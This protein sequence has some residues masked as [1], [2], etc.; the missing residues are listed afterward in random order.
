[1]AVNGSSDREI[2]ESFPAS[3]IR[4]NRGVS[5]VRSLRINRREEPPQVVLLYGA[6][7]TGKT[8]S[9]MS[10][11]EDL[12]QTPIG[13]YGWFDGY[14][15][16]SDVLLDDFAGKMSKCSLAELL[17]LIDRYSRRVPIKG[18]FTRFSPK[19]I[20]ITTNYHLKN[21]YDWSSRGPQWYALVRRVDAVLVFKEGRTEPSVYRRGTSS[22]PSGWSYEWRQW[23]GY[24]NMSLELKDVD[25]TTPPPRRAPK[26]KPF[27][28]SQLTRLQ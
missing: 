23:W 27:D 4:Y 11:T 14:D 13:G 20:F 2:V 21:W 16:H 9:V 22:V 6:P 28:L 15:E 8:S 24:P 25:D 19:R 17:A 5:K 7:G 18:G 10:S 26:F 12:W 3:Y 1:M